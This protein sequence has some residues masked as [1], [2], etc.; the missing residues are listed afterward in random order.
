MN[1]DSSQLVTVYDTLHSSLDYECLPFYVTDLVL[2]YMSA[3]FSA[4][5]VRRLTLHS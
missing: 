2:I 5:V 4:S 1:Y 3:T